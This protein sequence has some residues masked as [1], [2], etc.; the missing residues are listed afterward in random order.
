[1][2][3]LSLPIP[4]RD[5]NGNPL[6]AR[7]VTVPFTVP[8]TGTVTV[9]GPSTVTVRDRAGSVVAGPGTSVA[10]TGTAGKLYVAAVATGTGTVTV[11]VTNPA[12]DTISVLDYGAD[13]TGL[14]DSTSAIQAAIDRA[15]P[16]GTV[17]FPTGSYLI[18][19]PLV[20][21]NPDST[22]TIPTQIP[23][24]TGLTPPGTIGD[25]A[26]ESSP[27]EIVCSDTFPVG[28]F[29][30][31]FLGSNSSAAP[32]GGGCANLAIRCNNLGA[33][34]LVHQ[35]RRGVFENLNIYGTAVP[36]APADQPFG[37]SPEGAF[38]V[39]QSNGTAS[40]YN[41]FS[42]ISVA[43]AG[44]R[45]FDYNTTGKD[46]FVG[47]Y[48]LNPAT[49]SY[50]VGNGST[51]I[52]CMYSGGRTGWNISCGQNVSVV[53]SLIQVGTVSGNAVTISAVGNS[54]NPTSKASFVGCTIQN[55]PP[56]GSGSGGAAV[57][58][59]PNGTDSAF[60]DFT[61]CMFAAGGN[62][63][64]ATATAAIWVESGVTG[65]VRMTNCVINGTYA[66]APFVDDS[67]NSVVR[68][69]DVAGYNPVGPLTA[70]T[71]PASGTA[72]TNT[73]GVDATVYVTGGTV[74]A[75]AVDG[76]DTGM[77][78]GPVRLAAGQTIT[79]TYSA[80]PTWTWFGD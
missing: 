25:A 32:A 68:L 58:V 44:K 67:G 52:G 6:P 80:A 35:P 16:N 38:S 31:Q 46:V 2:L 57:L 69:R 63:G 3:L 11:T 71:M 41:R 53:G 7:P 28:Q 55:N 45:S 79:L 14:T 72:V 19:S 77:T 51:W 27:V 59:S 36:A 61:D 24:L 4:G 76:T 5:A 75:I 64:T 43:Y 9:T 12:V 37:I 22:T 74:T 1:M 33:G 60:V 65:K 62:S 21:Q 49:D 17:V 29:A 73:F 13:P 70:P 42:N 40:A 30:L 23:F 56:S 48:S 66:T 15:M 50:S 34:V 18:S 10:F 78:S 8:V 39:E 20:I 54:S 26:G 47:C